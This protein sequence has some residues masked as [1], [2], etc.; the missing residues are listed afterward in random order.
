M[1]S[2]KNFCTHYST[3][4]RETLPNLEPVV[5]G[6]NLGYERVWNPLPTK[7]EAKRR[8]FVSEVGYRLSFHL[9]DNVSASQLKDRIEMIARA[10]FQELSLQIN[11]LWN[12]EY[13]LSNI[14]IDEIRRLADLIRKYL[15]LLPPLGDNFVRPF[16]SGHGIL[17]NCY[18]D[19]EKD[20]S[21]IEMKYVSRNFRGT[22]IRQLLTYSALRYYK[23]GKEYRN[24][25]LFNPLR[26]VHF[27]TTITE[28]LSS[29]A[30]I[31]SIEFYKRMSYVL[32]SGEVSH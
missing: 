14:E 23:T 25:Y 15:M 16:Y 21:L 29:A 4:W 13:Y 7:S 22:D 17:G 20:D 8:D 3:F 6:I 18:G 27:P 12:E 19:F 10:V 5:R 2:E 1:I 11:D 31:T 26:G 24:L 32:S 28:I 9:S 30:G